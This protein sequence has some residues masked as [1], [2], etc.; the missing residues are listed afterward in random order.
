ME[1]KRV[2]PGQLDVVAGKWF[3]CR[4]CDRKYPVR[5][6]IPVMLIQEGDKYRNTLLEQL[7]ELGE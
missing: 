4:D 7:G 2:D 6:Q 1:E 3:V 5:N